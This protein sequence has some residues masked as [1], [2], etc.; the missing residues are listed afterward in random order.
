MK[1]FTTL[2]QNF[3]GARTLDYD[4]RAGRYYVCGG[5]FDG[6]TFDIEDLAEMRESQT[7]FRKMLEDKLA[8]KEAA[9]PRRLQEQGP[10]VDLRVHHRMFS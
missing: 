4:A 7:A 1:G 10:P 5:A 9:K 6:V 3:F 2:M 8:E